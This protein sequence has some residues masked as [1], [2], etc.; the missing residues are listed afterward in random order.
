MCNNSRKEDEFYK[1]ITPGFVDGKT[2]LKY[3]GYLNACLTD[4]FKQFYDNPRPQTGALKREQPGNA[5]P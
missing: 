2:R 3:D 4:F 5:Q 1:H